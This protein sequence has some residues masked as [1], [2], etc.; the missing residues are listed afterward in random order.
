GSTA[1]PPPRSSRGRIS[2]AASSVRERS[3]WPDT[4]RSD[5][6]TAASEATPKPR[7]TWTRPTPRSPATTRSSDPGSTRAVPRDAAADV[8]DG[9][10]RVDQRGVQLVA[11]PS[12][13]GA[14]GGLGRVAVEVEDLLEPV[15]VAG[16]PGI[17]GHQRAHPGGDADERGDDRRDV[18]LD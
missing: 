3:R 2:I 9:H 10:H 12:V 11:A 5:G 4:S 16:E 15:A 7:C 13:V 17:R 18:V 6:A 8:V 1:G 14:V